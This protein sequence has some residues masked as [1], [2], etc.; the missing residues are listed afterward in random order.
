MN[1]GPSIAIV[2]A[3]SLMVFVLERLPALR[4]RALPLRMPQRVAQSVRRPPRDMRAVVRSRHRA[5]RCSPMT[6]VA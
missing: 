4:F 5:E 2:P 1:R 3:T 6:P